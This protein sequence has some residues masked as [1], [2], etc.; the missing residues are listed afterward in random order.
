M[1]R[2]DGAGNVGNM[3][4]PEDVATSR[5]PTEIT[6]EWMNSLQEELAGFIEFS[7]LGLVKVDNTQLR[8]A[9]LAVVAAA[10]SGHAGGADPHP[11]Y[12][13]DADLAAAIAG[14]GLPAGTVI[15]VARST[16]PAGYLK[17]NGAAISRTTYAYLFAAIGTT[18]GAGD[19]STTFVVPDLR[20]E[21]LR[22]WDDG[23]GADSGRAFGSAQADDLKSHTHS[24]P[25]Q[26]TG[27]GSVGGTGHPSGATGA[28]SGATGGTET[29][30]RNVALLACIKY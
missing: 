8:Q 26:S 6:S 11:V 7:G 19:G 14:A 10:V 20:G 21:F 2:I 15:H 5:P 23:R 3:F 25:Q 29:R 28:N 18:F 17:A 16:T 13:T 12:A 24:L 27:Q 30:P 4:V 22:G 1:H 9:I